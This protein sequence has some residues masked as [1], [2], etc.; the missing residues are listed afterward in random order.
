[1]LYSEIIAVCSQIHTKRINTL[2]G[3]DAEFF[4]VKHGGTYSNHWA[5]KCLLHTT[6]CIIFNSIKKVVRDHASNR[7][8]VSLLL[9]SIN[10]KTCDVRQLVLPVYMIGGQTIFLTPRTWLLIYI[11][12]L[13]WLR[14]DRWTRTEVEWGRLEV[15]KWGCIWKPCVIIII[16]YF[17]FNWNMGLNSKF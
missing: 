4:S 12:P 5:L 3:Q 8:L 16:E 2:C 14:A 11:R 7:G 17:L 13:N 15:V 9:R 1:M 10:W 6:V